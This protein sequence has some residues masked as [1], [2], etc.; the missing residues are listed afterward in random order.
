MTAS[1][2]CVVSASRSAA[3][4]ADV[5]GDQPDRRASGGGRV[6]PVDGLGV[7]LPQVVVDDDLV[8]GP[9]QRPD[10]EAADEAGAAGHQDAAHAQRPIEK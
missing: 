7:A 8:A 3:A 10:G 6:E 2:R 5:A 9:G 4:V 1:I